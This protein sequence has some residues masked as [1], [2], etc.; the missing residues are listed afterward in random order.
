MA[1]FLC[2]ISVHPEYCYIFFLKFLQTVKLEQCSELPFVYILWPLTHGTAEAPPKD[3][4][5]TWEEMLWLQTAHTAAATQ[6]IL[7][8]SADQHDCRRHR[9][10]SKTHIHILL[11]TSFCCLSSSLM[12]I[13][14]ASALAALFAASL[15][16]AWWTDTEIQKQTDKLAVSFRTF[17]V[18]LYTEI[19][20]VP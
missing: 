1:F 13:S 6:E 10:A 4:K 2:F 18:E 3:Q 14:L 20:I 7:H 16:S 19:H 17:Y 8:G 11:D 12:R 9:L 15:A 5:E